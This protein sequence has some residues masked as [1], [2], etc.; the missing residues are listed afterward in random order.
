VHWLVRDPPGVGK[1]RDRRP[2]GLAGAAS[3]AC[4]CRVPPARSKFSAQTQ[5]LLAQSS[6][7]F[8]TCSVLTFVLSSRDVFCLRMCLNSDFGISRRIIDRHYKVRCAIM[9]R[10]GHS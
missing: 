5:A 8:L 2:R 6:S 9:L 7:E 3:V 10:E 4:S 1:A